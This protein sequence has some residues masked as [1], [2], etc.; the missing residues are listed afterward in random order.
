MSLPK[1]PF[2]SSTL[3]SIFLWVNMYGIVFVAAQQDA[4]ATAASNV[5]PTPSNSSANQALFANFATPSPPQNMFNGNTPNFGLA[6]QFNKTGPGSMTR[7][8]YTGTGSVAYSQEPIPSY[9]A[10]NLG[11]GFGYVG[12]EFQGA[13]VG[14]SSSYFQR[15]YSCGLCIKIQCDD[16]SCAV[17][18]K[19]AVAQIVDLCGACSAA[20]MNIAGPLFQNLTGRSGG[21]N[22]TITLSWEYVDC[23]P[24]INGTIKMLVKPGGTAYYQAFNFANARQ[25]IMAVQVNGQL[26]QHGSNNYWSWNPT[27]GP[28]NPNGPFDFAL[29]GANRQILQV[30]LTRLESVDLGV[31]F[32]PNASPPSAEQAATANKTTPPPPPTPAS[33]PAPAGVTLAASGSG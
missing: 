23:S 10:V 11:C 15:G 3:L 12:P 26:L 28:I 18:G 13:Y 9:G 22:P 5:I 30:R 6:P 1:L 32:A 20:D 25:P 2:L 19:T 16:I 4:F 33:A 31:Q 17:P 7:L 24:Y 14:V 21:T 27:G 8:N 29:L